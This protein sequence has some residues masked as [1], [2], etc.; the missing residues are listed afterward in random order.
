MNEAS[1]IHE[2]AALFWVQLNKITEGKQ[3]YGEER[4][5]PATKR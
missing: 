1:A 5:T 2:V 4:F 3:R